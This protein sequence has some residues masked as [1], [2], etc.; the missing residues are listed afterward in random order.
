MTESGAVFAPAMGFL[1]DRF[2]FYTSFTVASVAI[3]V[4][5]LA[6]LPLLRDSRD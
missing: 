6:C 1:L 4:V 3:I 5:V 2:G